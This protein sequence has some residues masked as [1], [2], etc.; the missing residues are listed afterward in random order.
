MTPVILGAL[1]AGI[2]LCVAVIAMR[3]RKERRVGDLRAVLEIAYSTPVTSPLETD[4]I[5]GLLARSGAVADR[6][7]GRSSLF[8]VITDRVERSDWS[9][10]PGEFVALSATAG[11]AGLFFGWLA[12]GPALALLLTGTGL[13]VPGMLVKRAVERR[14]KRFEAQFPDVLDLMGAGLEAGAG[15]AQALELVVS[16]AEDPARTEFGRALAATRLGSSLGEALSEM[17]TRIGSR[18]LQWTVHAITVQQQTGGRLADVLRT[19]AGF[20]RARDEI[21]RELNALVA[22]GKL[23]AYVLGGLPFMIAAFLLVFNPDYLRPLYTTVPG[24]V[25]MGLA[26]VLMVIGFFVMSRIIKVEV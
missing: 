25:M 2:G 10:S 15:V 5:S 9:I 17:S 19:V 7:L 3:A 1:M 14:K 21:R 23:S 6:A 18:D 13:V 4:E 8:G 16:E 22:E 20:M 24:F 26:S 11:V 12:G